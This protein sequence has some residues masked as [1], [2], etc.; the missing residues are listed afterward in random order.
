M[1]PSVVGPSGGLSNRAPACPAKVTE[2]LTPGYRQVTES[3]PL[4]DLEVEPVEHVPDRVEDA[5]H[6]VADRRD[7]VGDPVAGGADP[8]TDPVEAAAKHHPHEHQAHRS[9]A[10]EVAG[11]VG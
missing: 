7:A 5:A 1:V 8:V 9:E 4:D 3:G 11:C 10:P 6:T 2:K